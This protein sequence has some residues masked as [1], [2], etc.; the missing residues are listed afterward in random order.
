MLHQVA[1]I[2]VC[3]KNVVSLQ[4]FLD[5]QSE[6]FLANLNPKTA[7]YEEKWPLDLIGLQIY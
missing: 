3:S 5:H 7:L 2:R 6:T 4:K 1:P